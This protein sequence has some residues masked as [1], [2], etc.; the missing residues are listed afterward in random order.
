MSE[1]SIDA[2]RV[3]YDGAALSPETVDPNPTQQFLAWF[4]ECV[5]RGEVEPNAMTLATVDAQ[6]A[7]RARIVL[8]K[9][10]DAEGFVF[11]TNYESPKALECA[12][13]G[14]AALT[15]LW[16]SVA[17]QVRV[18]GTVER[19]SEAVSDAY[20]A[21]RPRASQLGAWASTQSAPV[22]DRAALE[23]SFEAA[24]ERFE[25]VDVTRPPHWGG[26]RVVPT[27]MEFWQG[28]PGRMH[29]RVVYERVVDGGWTR[30]RLA[31]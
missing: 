7:P 20:F 30:A 4:D 23:A 17:R 9:G 26:L 1:R 24:T 13:A 21:S 11:Y 8:L 19:V 22:A 10:A 14:R 2:M 29:D 28:H 25:G 6:G 12:S 27:R 16:H 31:P 5:A 3:V 15:F 18:E